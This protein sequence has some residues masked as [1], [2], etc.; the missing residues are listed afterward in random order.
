MEPSSTPTIKDVAAAAGVHFTTVS[1]ALRGHPS[2]PAGT[3][4]RII[5]AAARVGYR[6][7]KVFSALSSRRSRT[8]LEPY[9]PRIA[10]VCNRS[11]ANGYDRLTFMLRMEQAARRKADS[12]G[13]RFERF[14]LDD[15]ACTNESLLKQL[16]ENDVRGIVVANFEP[17]RRE[18]VLP[19]DEFCVVKVASQHMPPQLP[20]VSVDQGDAIAIGIRE[21]HA[22]G[23]RR[24]GIAV[25]MHD[26]ISSGDTNRAYYLHACRKQ[27]ITALEPML[28]PF[29]ATAREAVPLLK[30]WVKRERLDAVL[31]NWSNLRA[32]LRE[33][34]YSV[35]KEVAC[36][37]ICLGRHTAGLAGVVMDL[38]WVAEEAVS[39]LATLLRAERR[40]IPPFAPET[41]IQGKWKH[42]PTAPQR[43]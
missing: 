34:G 31:C 29:S 10:W 21:L 5:A 25:S 9:T 17:G 36:A 39:A 27:G 14:F 23:Y 11:P 32:M 16:R 19:W 8:N 13:Y 3:R 26:E 22:L 28:F 35:P 20:A 37:S 6:K 41:L 30:T 18:L 15:G 38:E 7:E 1:L 12:L 43:T 2:I 40:G 4:D 33:A 24:I 42:G